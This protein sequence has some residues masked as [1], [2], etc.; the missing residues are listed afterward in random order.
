VNVIR[1][2]G[3]VCIISMRHTEAVAFA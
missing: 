3:Q 2:E 1:V